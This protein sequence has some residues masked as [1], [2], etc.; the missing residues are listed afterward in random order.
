MMKVYRDSPVYLLEK[1]IV[2]CLFLLAG[3]AFGLP[4]YLETKTDYSYYFVPVIFLIIGGY[5]IYKAVVRN[6]VVIV[7]EKGL[8][9]S[10]LGSRHSQLIPWADIDSLEPLFFITRSQMDLKATLSYIMLK[11][12]RKLNLPEAKLPRLQF[13]NFYYPKDGRNALET[14]KITSDVQALIPLHRFQISDNYPLG[15]FFDW[16]FPFKTG[17]VEYWDRMKFY[18]EL[19]LKEILSY[20]P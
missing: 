10:Y 15:R 3:I 7:S 5:F 9:L 18:G 12:S 6:R 13:A 11:S 16:K 20:K 14:Q 4:V 8:I 17:I 2:G 1:I 19:T